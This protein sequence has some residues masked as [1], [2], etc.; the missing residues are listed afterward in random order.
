MLGQ[1]ITARQAAL[2][3][4]GHAAKTKTQPMGL[5]GQRHLVDQAARQRLE[6][7]AHVQ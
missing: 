6:H 5:G 4:A 1:H 7:K 2:V 3:H